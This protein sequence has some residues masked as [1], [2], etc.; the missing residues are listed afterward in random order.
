MQGSDHCPVYVDLKEEVMID[1]NAVHIS[2]IVNPPDRFINGVPNRNYD[3]RHALPLSARKLPE[4]AKRRN[5]RD[6]FQSGKSSLSRPQIESHK[7]KS[8]SKGAD[9]SASSVST[10]FNKPGGSLSPANQVPKRSRSN[11][12]QSIVQPLNGQ[13]SLVGFF[14]PKSP[15]NGTVAESHAIEISPSN[16]ESVAVSPISVVTSDHVESPRLVHGLIGTDT[17]LTKRPQSTDAESPI[18]QRELINSM[19]SFT[20]E[21]SDNQIEAPAESHDSVES[22]ISW[23]RLFTKPH[24]PRCQGHNEPCIVMTSK[25]KGGNQGRSFWMC[26]RPLGPSG[27]KERGTEWRCG[28]FIWCSDWRQSP[29]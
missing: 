14:K 20:H 2:D 7:R 21:L 1:G 24:P 17:P 9:Y 23:S 25:K 15:T 19:S 4:F 8:P 22:K 3:A 6:M 26:R 29:S 13:T 5:I 12:S 28:F 10:P 27:E 18:Q 16:V 11:A